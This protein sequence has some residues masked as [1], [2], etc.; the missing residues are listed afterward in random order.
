MSQHLQDAIE[1]LQNYIVTHQDKDYTYH[2][3]VSAMMIY[4]SLIDNKKVDGE[5]ERSLPQYGLVDRFFKVLTEYLEIKSR[6][7]ERSEEVDKQETAAEIRT[8]EIGIKFLSTYHK[9]P[10]G[11][12]GYDGAG[13]R[14]VF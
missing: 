5:F 10:S 14:N 2:G 8:I 1:S 11:I 9:N 4:N 6:E 7:Y 13:C 3:D 12:A